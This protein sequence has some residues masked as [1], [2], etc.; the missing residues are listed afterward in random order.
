RGYSS[1]FWLTFRQA[2][3]LGGSVRK[4]QRSVA[5]VFWKILKKKDEECQGDEETIRVPLLRYYRVFNVEQCEGL[6]QEKIPVIEEREIQPL[7]CAEQIVAGMPCPPEIR[8]GST[9]AF[10]SPE[11]DQI[12]MPRRGFF[13]T[14]QDYFST[15]FHE[16]THSTGAKSR[17]GRLDGKAP[18]PFGSAEYSREE[19]VAEMGAAFLCGECGIEQATLENSA[20][21]ISHWLDKLKS[22]PRLVVTAAAQ[23]Q[24]AADFILGRYPQNGKEEKGQ[25]PSE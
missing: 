21:Y 18:A 22:D 6:P 12:Q 10:Y 14:C 20:A 7:K 5:V 3:Q 8:H 25:T 4:G 15:L 1:P 24:K 13:E 2:K 17:L 16:L 9:G 23:A 19:L 11:A